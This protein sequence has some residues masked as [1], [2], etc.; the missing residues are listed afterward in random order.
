M[1][2]SE[3]EIQRRMIWLV[4]YFLPIYGPNDHFILGLTERLHKIQSVQTPVLEPPLTIWEAVPSSRPAVFFEK[5]TERFLS[6]G[7]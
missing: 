4:N 2:N 1:E 5:Q 6:S 7:V 3:Q